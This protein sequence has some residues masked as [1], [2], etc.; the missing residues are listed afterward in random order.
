MSEP[1][2]SSVSARLREIDPVGAAGAAAGAWFVIRR[3][4]FV[5][6]SAGAAG[7]GG[8]AAPVVLGADEGS[9]D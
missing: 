8:A 6:V 4:G 7:A 5:E 2:P 9:D 3:K 1:H